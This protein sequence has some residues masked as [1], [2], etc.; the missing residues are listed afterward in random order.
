MSSIVFSSR[1]IY[2]SLGVSAAVPAGDFCFLTSSILSAE[3]RH[4]SVSLANAITHGG[5]APRAP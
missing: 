4:L 1:A 2:A 5:G 3:R